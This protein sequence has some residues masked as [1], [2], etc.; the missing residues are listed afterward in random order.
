M[1][2]TASTSTVWSILKRKDLDPVG[3]RDRT[4]QAR[5]FEGPGLGSRCDYGGEREVRLTART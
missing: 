5:V 4:D 3:G 1:G 2:I